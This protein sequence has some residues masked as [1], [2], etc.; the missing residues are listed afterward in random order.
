MH[1]N[2]NN[3][4]IFT[5]NQMPGN[6]MLYFNCLKRSTAFKLSVSDAIAVRVFLIFM[7]T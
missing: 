3:R 2:G 7:E 6:N 5:A 4:Y 1:L